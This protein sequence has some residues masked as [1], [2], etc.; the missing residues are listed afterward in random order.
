[1]INLIK[2][3]FREKEETIRNKISLHKIPISLKE[4]YKYERIIRKETDSELKAKGYW[5][6]S[7]FDLNY[8]KEKK[9]NYFRV[10]ETFKQA[11]KVSINTSIYPEILFLLGNFYFFEKLDL[12]K[13]QEIYKR[14]LKEYPNNK[15]A[16]VV[17]ERIEL[18]EK[19]GASESI[20][21]YIKAEKY[22]ST[23][24]YQSAIE[25]LDELIYKF[26]QS[27]LIPDVYYL[28]GDIYYF[29]YNNY[30]KAI[31]NY[32][33]VVGRY[34]SSKFSSNC[35]YKIGECY[36]KLNMFKEAI[37]AYQE[38]IHNY[39][40]VDFIDYAYYYI[41]DSYEK[42]QNYSRSKLYYELILADFPESVWTSVAIKSLKRI[43]EFLNNKPKL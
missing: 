30:I 41:A 13:T 25:I 32:K 15:W 1:M 23:K 40:N 7:I 2:K 3:F 28:K 29:K 6:I 12:N 37:E 27:L 10:E 22:F 34:P 14:L 33:E 11:L 26:P 8:Y 24:K 20:Q 42:L 5:L 18:I 17:N 39:K 36:R 35:Q 43:R 9:K 16:V 21:H 19:H 4:R 31:E 38:F